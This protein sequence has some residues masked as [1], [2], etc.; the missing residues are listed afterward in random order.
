MF[1]FS[2]NVFVLEPIFTKF[3]D[4]SLKFNVK[5][6]KIKNF[7]NSQVESRDLTIF[8]QWTW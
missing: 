7:R 8:G 4:F 3:V 2:C 1:Y 5:L 6:G